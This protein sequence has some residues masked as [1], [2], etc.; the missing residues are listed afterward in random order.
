MNDLNIILA[1]LN[2][3]VGDLSGNLK[4]I[5]NVRD[6]NVDADLIVYS[7]LITCGY[8]ADDLILKP[9]FI[10]AIEK[11]I[12]QL[13]EESKKHTPYL[14]ISTP[15]R[16]EGS[17][18]NTILVIGNGKIQFESYKH[19]LPNDGVFDEKRLFESGPLPKP[20][21]YKETKIGLMTCEDM[22]H[23]HVS[24]HLASMGAEIF[25]VPNGSP[26]HTEVHD[27]RM[28]HAR[29]RNQETGLPI[30]YVNQVGGQDELVF[31]GGSFVMNAKGDV[32]H[33]LPLF[34]EATININDNDTKAEN[35]SEEEV[36]YKALKLG[37]KDYVEKNN[38]PGVLIGLSGGIDSA[39]SA[40]I[41]VDALGADK[42]QCVMMPSP[43]TS[44]DSLDD[45]AK[46]A[47][48]LDVSLES[49]SIEEA[50]KAFDAMI[51][52][53]IDENAAG[54]T[55]ENIQ[56][57]IRGTTLMALSNA[58][59]HMVL[60]TGNKSEM[61]VGYATLY[62]DMCGGFNALKDLYKGQVYALSKWRNEKGTVIPE[63]IITKAPS[64]ELKPDQ[65]DQDSLPDYSVLD[66]ILQGLIEDDL[67]T[68]E[69][70]KNTG[71]DQAL[72]QKIWR[73]LD[74]A[75]YKRRQAPPGV[76][77]TPKAFGRNRRYP[78]TNKFK[79]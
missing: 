59:G 78:I 38:F 34:E 58:S 55:F 11:Q 40:A 57:R 9:S 73:M 65:T 26:F 27:L 2:P 42:V 5:Q 1:Q 69:I 72:V 18:F 8:P 67:S 52:T 6:S 32:T 48:L 16:N 77:I 47:E 7:E 60:S 43:Y 25:I 10:D 19:E 28:L 15:W 71:H 13:V 30:L 64:A 62:G 44:Q 68:T 22:W 3:T 63:R 35:L 76:K 20:Y 53:H 79:G 14:I 49:L 51:D 17:L 23:P 24:S 12:E 31:D 41:A 39:L 29:V 61:A 37:L 70:A 75:E 45:A 36:I 56:S 50:M 33:S 54:T 74:I 21:V 66:E 46:C 4:K